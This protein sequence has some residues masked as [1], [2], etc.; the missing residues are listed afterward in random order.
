MISLDQWRSSIGGW[1]GRVSPASS[2]TTSNST[3][4]TFMDADGIYFEIM[5]FLLLWNSSIGGC[6]SQI[7]PASSITTHN[8]SWRTFIDRMLGLAAYLSAEIILVLLIIGGVEMNPGPPKIDPN[9]SS[10]EDETNPNLTA[11]GT[12]YIQLLIIDNKKN[13]HYASQAK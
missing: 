12:S 2:L 10:S 3:C 13:C 1:A 8:F 9:S 4:G 6:A 11:S 5:I 7:R